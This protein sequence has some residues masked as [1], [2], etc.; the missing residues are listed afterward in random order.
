MFVRLRLIQVGNKTREYE[1]LYE[2][3]TLDFRISVRYIGETSGA[4]QLFAN[5]LLGTE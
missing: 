2:V 4:V 1:Q 3:T 5:S